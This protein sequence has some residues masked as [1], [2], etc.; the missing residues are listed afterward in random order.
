MANRFWIG[1]SGNINDTAHWSTTS[2]GSGGASV[3]TSADNATWDA[4]SSSGTY[5]VT[6]N[7]NF[8][9]ANWTTGAPASGTLTFS[10]P[11]YVFMVY[12][13]VS[14]HLGLLFSG[15]PANTFWNLQPPAGST[16]YV[17]SNGVTI[18]FGWYIN[19][20]TTSTTV[21][22]DDL[23]IGNGSPIEFGKGTFDAN[24]KNVT[25]SYALA[26]G[27]NAKTIKL[28]TGLWT[29]TGTSGWGIAINA[30]SVTTIVLPSPASGST[31]KLTANSSSNTTFDGGG[32]TYGVLEI[33]TQGTGKVAH[34]SS[35]T[36]DTFKNTAGAVRRNAFTAGT[37]T[38]AA[39][40]ILSGSAGNLNVITSLT[41]AQHTLTKSG[42]GMVNAD[43]LDLSWSK[44]LPSSPQTWYAGTHSNNGGNNTNWAFTDG[45][46]QKSVS[47]ALSFSGSLTT[48]AKTLSGVTRDSA[49]NALGNC[50]VR[51]LSDTSPRLQ[52][53]KATSDVNGNYSIY[54][55]YSSSVRVLV[56]KTGSP[57]VQGLSDL[58]TPQ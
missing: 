48:N 37:N 41:G 44:G 30:V 26:I 17:T 40:W 4:N 29:L 2:G 39:N 47:G 52:V 1:G 46:I 18:P 24:G 57:N 27:T 9:C 49:G 56:T 31:I 36:F 12:G 14:L 16:H 32:K 42:G 10:A 5:T 3:P 19:G 7:A 55:A 34:T 20:S 23:S 45:A 50:L 8:S 28:G 21:L 58:V 6:V 13:D 25:A 51:L 22:N 11:T 53:G 38:T 35:N 15:V 54:T 33:A 43:Y